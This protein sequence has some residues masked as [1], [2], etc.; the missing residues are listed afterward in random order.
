MTNEISILLVDDE[1]H[2]REVLSSGPPGYPPLV[3]LAYQ[4]EKRI[5]K[6]WELG[7]ITNNGVT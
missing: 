5:R 7:I 4:T 1:T 2:Y 3:N 6:N